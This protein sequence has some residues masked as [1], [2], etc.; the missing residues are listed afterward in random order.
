M[1]GMPHI[2]PYHTKPIFH[3]H[4]HLVSH[5]L[6]RTP[7]WRVQCHRDQIWKCPYVFSL[8]GVWPSCALS[9]ASHT[10]ALVQEKEIQRWNQQAE[11][12][13]PARVE[14]GTQELALLDQVLGSEDL[15]VTQGPGCR[16]LAEY[17]QESLGKEWQICRVTFVTSVHP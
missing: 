17:A 16:S 9:C 14:P 13:C 15:G 5:I 6:Y 10:L 4:P 2:K 1:P 3:S 7:V 12:S 8:S 11:G